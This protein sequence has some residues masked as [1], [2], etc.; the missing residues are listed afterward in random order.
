MMRTGKHK[1]KVSIKGILKGI[2]LIFLPKLGRLLGFSFFDPKAT[3]FIVSVIKNQLKERQNNPTKN[4]RNDFID[5]LVAALN[6]SENEQNTVG[7][8]EDQFEK[9]AMLNGS[10]VN[11]KPP[12]FT[13]S[14]LEEA[15][16][17][18]AF[19]LFFAGFDTTSTG[20]AQVVYYLA[21]NP[22]VQ[23]QL[24]E[25]LLEAA[26]K[27]GGKEKLGYNEI[28]TLPYLEMV[29]LESLRNYTAVTP[30]ERECAEEYHVPGTDYVI[31]K[32]VIV[33]IP[34]PNM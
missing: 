22:N 17:C 14:E 20:M 28:Q 8:D 18:N 34:V 5:L 3:E 15:I 7:K 19:L 6:A 9:D 23:D 32:G 12:A 25:E 4:K 33:Q 21:K 27:A 26:E 31:E 29:V 24:Y 30:L 1:P 2:I 13:Q 10:S 16:V 11:K